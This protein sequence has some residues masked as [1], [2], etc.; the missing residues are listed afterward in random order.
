MKVVQQAEQP[1]LFSNDGAQYRHLCLGCKKAA[2]PHCVTMAM[3]NQICLRCDQDAWSDARLFCV[4]YD[5]TLKNA[6]A[7]VVVRRFNHPSIFET[8]TLAMA[9]GVRYL[10]TCLS[11]VTSAELSK[12]LA[13]ECRKV[14]AVHAHA[15]HKL[16]IPHQYFQSPEV[17]AHQ[18]SGA[19]VI[20][21]FPVL[22]QKK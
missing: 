13:D 11:S 12:N 3:T 15:W 7:V 16:T 8:H 1:D 21:V 9:A 6:D 18:C 22:R 19:V 4:Y 10:E 14:Y 5:V 2:C 20:H 17:S